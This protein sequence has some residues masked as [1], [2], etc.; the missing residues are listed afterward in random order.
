MGKKKG[1]KSK[2][3]K[4]ALNAF[5]AAVEEEERVSGRVGRN[6]RIT[7][8][9]EPDSNDE[10]MNGEVTKKDDE[11][12]D[13]DEALGSDDENEEF[14]GRYKSRKEDNSDNDEEGYDS[15]DESQLLPLSE[16][17]D[18]NEKREREEEEDS[19]DEGRGDL[20]L[21]QDDE[22]ESSE[23]ESSSSDDGDDEGESDLS[24]SDNE[25]DEDIDE[26]KLSSLRAQIADM[27]NAE[28]VKT[29]GMSRKERLRVNRVAENEFA[30][31]TSEQD[32][33]SLADLVSDGTENKKVA[34]AEQGPLAVPL[35]KRIQE[36]HDRTA[37]YGL[38]KEEVEK[39]S[40]TVKKNREAEYLQFPI[41]APPQVQKNSI[42]TPMA[43]STNLEKN[44]DEVLKASGGGETETPSTFEEL[45]PAKLSVEEIKKRRNELRLMREIM[46]RQE[47]KAK[48][49]KKIKSK[50]Y[51]KVHKRERERQNQMLEDE[52]GGSDAE[53]HDI[54]RAQER[55]SLRHKNTGRWAKNMINQGFTKD[56][57]T[58][59]ELEEM[60]RR[61]EDLKK[62]IEG[63]DGSDQEDNDDQAFLDND[64][65]ENSED[66]RNRQSLGKGLLGMKFMRDA[67]DRQRQKNKQDIEALRDAENETGFEDLEDGNG[68]K[69]NQEINTGR[70]VFVPGTH[71]AEDNMIDSLQ[72]A[73]DD[74]EEEEQESMSSRI[75]RGFDTLE[76]RQEKTVQK[77]QNKK[78][79]KNKEEA[80]KQGEEEEEESNPWLAI[81]SSSQPLESSKS[82]QVIDKDST[83]AQ[84]AQDK[85]RRQKNKSKASASTAQDDTIIDMNETLQVVDPLASDEEAEG[86][87]GAGETMVRGRGK[88]MSFKQKDLVKRAF[89]GDDVVADFQDEKR[90]KVEEEGDQ[91]LDVTIPGWGSWGG[92]G[93]KSKRKVVKK[94][95]GIKEKKRKD[96]KLKNV[97]INERVNK[98]NNKY[99]ASA[100]PFPFENREQYE[101]SL[102]MPVGPEWSSRDT[103]QRLTKPRVLVK[104]GTVIDPIKA[105]FK[106]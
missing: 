44:V 18:L 52:E 101:R 19:D 60:L 1:G 66:E 39:W 89:A 45:A 43:P 97:I 40:D 48:R 99:T 86:G 75:T 46:F 93:A 16:I 22:E 58:R 41:N 15:I 81:D 64:S 73:K 12:I 67:E 56:K 38:T 98:K 55:M 24:M 37:A 13:S 72:Q 49:I 61:G 68:V 35:P 23:A 50:S 78:L 42:Y 27:S 90:R 33:L 79:N 7:L 28:P 11:E 53:D 25:D 9:E 51:R 30:L 102:R 100:V 20:K 69:A 63:N 57:E 104:Q 65:E 76:T 88:L 105:P 91:E 70:R 103:H 34:S 10:L 92:N 71:D 106:S 80:E 17:W 21:R 5:D 62:K 87:D 8:S 94:V 14:M 36:R 95:E 85:I 31:P 3:T 84:K 32:D 96:A 2:H 59:N 47:Q 4:L 26:D 6:E 29:A 77:K 82:V 54:K 83:S 74:L